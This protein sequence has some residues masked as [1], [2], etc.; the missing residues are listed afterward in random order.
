MPQQG[1]FLARL[2]SDESDL[3]S[4]GFKVFKIPH[5]VLCQGQSGF[6]SA[7][8]RLRQFIRSGRLLLYFRNQFAP[9]YRLVGVSGILL[10]NSLLNS[11]LNQ[12]ALL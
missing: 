12:E 1:R 2:V 4:S 11:D 8:D 10:Q 9:D 6:L 7:A 5:L 3:R